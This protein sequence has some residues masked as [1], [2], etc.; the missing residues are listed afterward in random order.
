M[1]GREF[2]V[3]THSCSALAPASSI[4]MCLPYPGVS[5]RGAGRSLGNQRCFHHAGE[6]K[7]GVVEKRVPAPCLKEGHEEPGTSNGV[8]LFIQA[9]T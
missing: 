7:I 2:M 8:E 1:Q 5:S 6:P 9:K 4:D 3:A